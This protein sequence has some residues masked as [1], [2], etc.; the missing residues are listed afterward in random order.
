MKKT[1]LILTAAAT[2]A[3]CAG[4]W[5]RAN[6]TEAEFRR[7]MYQCEQESARTYPTVMQ[8]YGAGVRAPDKTTCTQ[9]GNQLNCSSTSGAFTPPPQSDANAIPRARGVES[10]MYARGYMYQRK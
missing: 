7:D 9:N 8:S 5:N 6:T 3:G 10:C 1:I 4:G 2:L